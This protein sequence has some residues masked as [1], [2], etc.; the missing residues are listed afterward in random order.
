MAAPT[1]T[2][3]TPEEF[4]IYIPDHLKSNVLYYFG[5]PKEH[6]KITN[7]DKVICKICRTKLTYNAT[8]TNLR[9]H[10]STLHPGKLEEK[11][12]KG[13]GMRKGRIDFM[14]SPSR[15][16]PYARQNRVTDLLTQFVCEDMRPVN[17]IYGSGFQA[18]V[19]EL[20]PRLKIPCYRTM[21][22]TKGGIREMLGREKFA[23]TTDGWSSLA[24]ES[25]VTVTAHFIDKDWEMRNV[26]LDMPELQT[27]H[28]VA[29]VSTCINSIL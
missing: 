25:H 24:T 27:A 7:K 3:T 19:H 22:T 11:E 12:G 10:L 1:P 5:F 29:N 14:L 9:A 8:T 13:S 16:L 23:L 4:E 17:V 28:T 26:I 21:N 20:E 18:F 2:T 15:G 6:G